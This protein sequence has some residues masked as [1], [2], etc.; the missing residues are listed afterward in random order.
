MTGDDL[1]L[2][3]KLEGNTKLLKKNVLA[4]MQRGFA[5]ELSYADIARNISNWG[6]ADMNRSKTIARTEGHRVQCKAD[7][8]CAYKARELGCDTVKQW[9]STL[10]GKTRE[11]HQKLDKEWQEL[12]EPF[13]NGLMYPGDPDSK[14]AEVVNCRCSLDDVP[15]WYVEKGGA[16]YRRDNETGNIIEC[17]NYAEFKEKYLQNV[18]SGVTIKKRTQIPYRQFNNGKDVNDFFYYDSVERGLLAKKNSK[19]G[20]WIKSLT[21]DERDALSWYTADGYGDVNDFWRKRNGWEYINAEN[22]KEASKHLD[23]IISRFE[24][25]DNIVVQ[26]GVEDIFLPSFDVD[27]IDSVE[28]LIGK[29]FTDAGYGSSTALLG[30]PIATRKPVLYEIEIPAGKGRGAYINKFGGQ[31]ED[32]EYEFLMPRNSRYTVTDVVINDEPIPAQT[33]IKMR[34]ITDD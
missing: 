6:N 28:D 24:L 31:Y 9:N 33:I 30:N 2:S 5:S 21:P 17:K 16:K 14:A 25:K 20:Q 26:R 23:D 10:D 13:S 19:H 22:V 18:A 11:S 29:T 34:M 3:E 15:R 4:E 7:L 8:D 1:K 12:D 27:D 32:V